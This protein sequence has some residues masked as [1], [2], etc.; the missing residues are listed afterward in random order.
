MPSNSVAMK[1]CVRTLQIYRNVE[2]AV[3]TSGK[4]LWHTDCHILKMPLSRHRILLN[5]L[6]PF[7]FV[8][9]LWVMHIVQGIVPG[10]LI[11]WALYPRTTEGLTGILAHPLLH[12]DFGHL[13]GNSIP[14]LVLGF[15]L[16]NA[17]KDIAGKIFWLI[18][19]LT[20]V[21]M[22]LFARNAAHLGASGVV[23]G[24]AAFIFFSGI[25]RRHIRLM[26]ISMLV[27]FLYGY[28]VWGVLPIDPGVS[29]EGHLFGALTGMMLAWVYRR[30]GPQRQRFWENET[31]E[32]DEPDAPYLIDPDLLSTDNLPLPQ[33]D[34][35][36]ANQPPPVQIIYSY[37]DKKDGQG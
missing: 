35:P 23:Y 3:T 37:K 20:G 33:T 31:E 5:E 24:L 10:A 28:L 29:W 19:L 6:F 11:S 17:Y 25:I 7:T 30:Q 8:V 36:E 13:I 26:V 22:W 21:L 18:Y 32:E 16:F 14:L 15:L 34:Q 4:R 1:R 2:Y 12:G 9:L 27:A